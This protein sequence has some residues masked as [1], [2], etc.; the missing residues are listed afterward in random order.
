MNEFNVAGM[1]ECWFA[2]PDYI[3]KYAVR[4]RLRCLQSLLMPVTRVRYETVLDSFVARILEK[5]CH[6]QDEK[7]AG[8]CTLKRRHTS[9]GC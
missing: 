8:K 1:Y 7:T 5:V 4:N 2:N 9:G 3:L 6:K